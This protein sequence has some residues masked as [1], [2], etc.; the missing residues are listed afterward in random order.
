MIDRELNQAI[1]AGAAKAE[2]DTRLQKAA[3][4]AKAQGKKTVRTFDMLRKAISG[5]PEQRK[6]EDEEK[7]RVAA[8]TEAA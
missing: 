6:K 2:L 3:E 7:K 1:D 4:E 5:D 8:E